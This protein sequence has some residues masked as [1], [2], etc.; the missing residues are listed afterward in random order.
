MILDLKCRIVSRKYFHP[1]AYV[2]AYI[3]ALLRHLV[4]TLHSTVGSADTM[5]GPGIAV[6]GGE[7]A[8]DGKV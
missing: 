4:S 1:T 5:K 6:Q 2:F 8:G 7:A 3:D